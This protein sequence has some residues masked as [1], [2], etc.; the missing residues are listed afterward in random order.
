MTLAFKRTQSHPQKGVR[1][2]Y[3]I[4]PS[5]GVDPTSTVL[6]ITDGRYSGKVS[7][8]KAMRWIET[9]YG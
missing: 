4:W 9:L 3:A 6:A 5:R 1:R 8:V 7:D 2:S